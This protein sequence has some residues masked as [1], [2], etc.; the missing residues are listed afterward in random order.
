[1]YIVTVEGLTMRLMTTVVLIYSSST[2]V[3][4]TDEMS[5]ETKARYD[6]RK[7]P[8]TQLM[9]RDG[10]AIFTCCTSSELDSNASRLELM[11]DSSVAVSLSVSA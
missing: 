10:E 7:L 3:V 6:S 4:V 9:K 1:M 5:D 11:R 2:H 8:A